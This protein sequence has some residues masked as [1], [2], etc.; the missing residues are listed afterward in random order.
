[1]APA[2][3][4]LIVVTTSELR[5]SETV[6]PT[7]EGEPASHE[8]ALGLKYLR[9]LE[10]AG[11]IPL[12][13]PPLSPELV[14]SL[15]DRVD[16]VCLSGGPDL[17]PSAYGQ[18]THPAT[19]PVEPDL[20]AFELVLTRGADA[21]GLPILAI[22]RGMQLL[23]VARGGSLH[24]HLPEL[25][26]G[27]IDHRQATPGTEPTHVV[28]LE[29]RSHVARVL[30]IDRAEVNSFHHQAVDRLG[31]GLVVAGRA[32]DGTVEA[33]EAIDRDF[34]LGVQ[35]HAESL[36]ARPEQAALFEA[37]VDAAQQRRVGG[38]QLRVA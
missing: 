37:F 4:P 24:Q 8:M 18:G 35:W 22:C 6:S 5:R 31:E 26:S 20:D 23:N 19:G 7:P 11:A 10:M 17:D 34:V 21:L 36:T 29:D 27:E 3:R 9:A 13:I 32:P 28:A 16:G 33:I 25:V 38:S 1:V 14:P 12:V 30:R 15:L 2:D